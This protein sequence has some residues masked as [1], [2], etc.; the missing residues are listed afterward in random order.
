MNETRI[1]RRSLLKGMGYAVTAPLLTGIA[2]PV[3]ARAAREE[4]RVLSVRSLHTDEQAREVV[5]WD[6][7][8]YLD[9]GLR[10]VS[11]VLR[12]WRTDDIHPVDPSLLDILFDLNRKVEGKGLFHVISGYRSPKTNAMLSKRSNGVARKS[13]HMRGMAV[14]VA[15]PGCSLGNLRRAALGMQRGGVGYYPKSGFV[16][17]DTGRV[18]QWGG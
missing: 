17:L 15:L 6:N 12:D 16:H 10:A 11:R 7:G 3:R 5:Y 9:D 14:D 8:D 13:L 4:P 1:S 18:R 2:S